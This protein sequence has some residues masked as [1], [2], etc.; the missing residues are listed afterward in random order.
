MNAIFEVES[1]R[2]EAREVSKPKRLDRLTF[3]IE[4]GEFLAIVGGSGAGKSTLLK[5]LIGIEK[6]SGEIYLNGTKLADSPQLRQQIGYVPQ[7][8]IVHADLTIWEALMAAARLRLPPGSK[9]QDVVTKTLERVGLSA[10]KRAKIRNLSGGQRKRVSIGIELLSD[11][12]LLLLDEPTSGLDPALDKEM[13]LLLKQLADRGSAVAIVTHATENIT[14]CD[15]VLYLGRGGKMCFY[16]T[17]SECLN[18]FNCDNF[19]DVY[20]QLED[21]QKIKTYSTFYR[22]SSFYQ[23]HVTA[24]LQ[25]PQNLQYPE[26]IVRNGWRQWRILSHRD[27][28]LLSRDRINLIVAL[29]TAPIGIWLLKIA[30]GENQPFVGSYGQNPNGAIQATL[31]FASACLWVGLAA[32][33]P[34]IVKEIPIYKRERMV[35][36]K[37]RPYLGAKLFSLGLL[38]IV[39]SAI[40][41]HVIPKL[42]TAPDSPL[43]PWEPG[44][45]IVSGFTILASLSLGLCISTIAQSPA[46]A[47]TALPLLL[48]PQIVFS[49][50]L[51]KLDGA[52]KL[53]SSL[54]ITKWS[55]V[56]FSSLSD[57]NSLVLRL[58]G[59]ELAFPF[60]SMYD[61][62]WE[63]FGMSLFALI[64]QTSV[65]LAIAMFW[66]KSKRA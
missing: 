27:G 51:F 9:Y 20:R 7:D 61:K 23:N 2:I 4:P 16:G 64:L 34:Q 40:V 14:M 18:Y 39:Q 38:A 43:M 46:Q 47:N 10:R 44:L 32:S 49:G 21:E 11:P 66:Q 41:A 31:V 37:V 42:F 26:T 35:G 36:L 52:A 19:T 33:L 48:I 45:A 63:N 8:D 17:P 54:T 12:K 56:G 22:N 5:A 6:T 65:Y 28:I 15:R 58:S 24:R 13:M 50:T 62:S 29:V 30:L 1:M 59:Q 57:I 55:I 53:L 3:T 25:T 60:G